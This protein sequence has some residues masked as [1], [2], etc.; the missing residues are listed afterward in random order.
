MRYSSLNT[1]LPR[2]VSRGLK[3]KIILGNP[4]GWIGLMFFAMGL[5]FALI[6]APM[7]DLRFSNPLD[8]SPSLTTGTV[9]NVEETSAT[10]NKKKILQFDF[11]YFVNEVPYYGTSYY[12]GDPGLRPGDEVTVEY[13]QNDPGLARIQHFRMA[14]Y[15]GDTFL[16]M[17]I[18][19]FVGLML[20][21]WA[22]VKGRK[23]IALVRTGYVTTGKVIS[24]TATNARIN[25]RRVYKIGFEYN[26]LDGMTRQGT[27]KTHQ[28][29]RL[30]DEEDELLLFNP[31]QPDEAILVDA[32]PKAVRGF[33]NN[34]V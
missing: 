4:R 6:F 22:I 32:L 21:T 13:D 33:I 28:P 26:G 19:P 17:L 29:E 8:Q 31:D 5:L 18:F 10:E 1:S 12:R 23:I 16:L 24:K 9:H 7:S 15:N 20:L 14:P 11:D 30:E 3:A 34:A 27:V 2:Q 25:K